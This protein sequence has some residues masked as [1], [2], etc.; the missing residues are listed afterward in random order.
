LE[1]TERRN[2]DEEEE[3]GRGE[4]GGLKIPIGTTSSEI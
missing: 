2:I 4:R 1:A 3:R